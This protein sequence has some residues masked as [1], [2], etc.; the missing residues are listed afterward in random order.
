MQY[1]RTRTLSGKRRS[2][3]RSSHAN[4]PGSS[5]SVQE[6]IT[7]HIP[8]QNFGHPFFNFPP[9]F[10]KVADLRFNTGLDTYGTLRHC[11]R[12]PRALE[13]LPIDSPSNFTL[14]GMFAPFSQKIF[15]ENPKKIQKIS[16]VA[17]EIQAGKKSRLKSDF[18]NLVKSAFPGFRL[19]S[20]L[21]KSF[22]A[23]FIAFN[24]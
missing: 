1:T 9:Y 22:P 7:P 20:N 13:M 4:H 11:W 3:G 15:S 12:S 24:A 16:P 17:I 23:P 8:Q 6:K 18:S 2:S 5:P 19:F 21:N 14:N 10:F